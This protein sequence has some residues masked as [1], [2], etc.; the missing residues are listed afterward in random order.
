MGGHV[1]IP[2]LG[3]CSVMLLG[4]M[5]AGCYDM[6]SYRTRYAAPT[7]GQP[8]VAAAPSVPTPG[9]APVGFT[10]PVAVGGAAPQ[11]A[12]PTAGLATLPP[13]NLPVHEDWSS[14]RCPDIAVTFSGRSQP[15]QSSPSD[16]ALFQEARQFRDH[17]YYE[18]AECFCTKYG[19][20]SQTTRSDADVAMTQT[21]Q[22]FA[23][24][25]HLRV[26][27]A[28]FVEDSPL[29]K[30]SEFQAAAQP[31]S[32]TGAALRT[33]WRGQCSIR[34][35]VIWDQATSARALQF[36]NSLHEIKEAAADRAGA[37]AAA[38]APDAPVADPAPKVATTDLAA[39]LERR[40]KEMMKATAN[41]AP[42]VVEAPSSAAATATTEAASSA[43]APATADAPSSAAATGAAQ[44]AD[45]ALRL[46]Q[47]K[48]LE[49]KGF[50]SKD[51]YETKRQSILNSL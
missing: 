35:E 23:A 6:A 36:L 50:I 33:Y 10:A 3:L 16:S 38:A 15:L 43:A 24:A 44:P 40:H 31:P 22:Q 4:S 17:D 9:A 34:V 2:S 8:A 12:E 20:L 46:K 19:N 14:A 45:T 26:R 18:V 25:S 7:A 49:H 28:T 11:P 47:L 48:E 42:A 32:A 37:D 1:R 5:G 51:E 21:A 39:E 30:Y 29:G 27:S 41:A 13:L